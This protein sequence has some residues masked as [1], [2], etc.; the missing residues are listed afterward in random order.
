LALPNGDA[1]VQAQRG[2]QLAT[3]SLL[4]GVVGQPQ[5]PIVETGDSLPDAPPGN[6]V[7][8]CGSS[9]AACEDGQTVA[10]VATTVPQASAGIWVTDGAQVRKV[11]QRGEPVAD[12]P[13]STYFE[14]IANNYPPGL[15][16]G[17]NGHFAAYIGLGGAPS[18]RALFRFSHAEPAPRLVTRTGLGVPGFPGLVMG[19]VDAGRVFVDG[20]GNLVFTARVQGNALNQQWLFT[21]SHDQG[22]RVALRIGDQIALAGND[23]RTVSAITLTGTIDFPLPTGRLVTDEGMYAVHIAFADQSQAILTSQ[24]PGTCNDI[25]FNNDLV[26]FDPLDIDAFFSV[27]SEGPCPPIGAVCD[28]IDFNNDGSRYDPEDVDAFLRVFS[29]GPC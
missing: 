18:G 8:T 7:Q 27:F 4:R 21:W 20:V 1:L 9:S 26:E 12:L 15:Y 11:A 28:S 6:V 5:E 3:F 23:T 17:N 14:I 2:P 16:A 22:L 25:D 24:I 10:F 13:G 19:D 29:E